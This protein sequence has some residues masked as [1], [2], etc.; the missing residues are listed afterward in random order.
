MNNLIIKK[1]KKNLPTIEQYIHFMNNPKLATILI[2][3]Y[4]AMADQS[5]FGEYVNTENK[6]FR[7]FP[8]ASFN[9]L[10]YRGEN[11]I[12]DYFI[13][14]FLRINEY[15]I[16]HAVEWI[17]RVEFI[18]LI[19]TSPF[20]TFLSSESNFSV[21]DCHFDIDLEAIAQHYEFAT[22]YLDFST[23]IAVSMFFAYTQY[24]APGKY[25]PILD[26]TD[27]DP[28]LYIGDLKKIY[29]GKDKE[30][31]K[32]IGF[33]PASRPSI[34]KALAFELN[35]TKNH[36]G[37]NFTRIE[38]PKS[39]DMANGIYEHFCGGD[40]LF[41][42]EILYEYA[43]Y[44]REKYIVDEY[45]NLYCDKY[46]KDYNGIVDKLLNEGY[47][48]TNRKIAW[49]QNDINF[50][51]YEISNGLIPWLENNITYRGISKGIGVL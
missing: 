23:D 22:N 28:V 31:F 2:N 46:K 27:Y 14:R 17:K 32:I 39:I 19:K 29:Q 34:Q 9:P 51:N 20:V 21:L 8:H 18:E 33:Q 24:I 11:K 44:L 40:I 36:F 10:I 1:E 25:K 15:S 4:F 43:C 26:F 13:P 45:L 5:Y 7:I 12:Y 16:E 48:I 30:A 37:N 47:E 38:L 6:K 50:M 42:N 41:P 35:D 3:E 49:S